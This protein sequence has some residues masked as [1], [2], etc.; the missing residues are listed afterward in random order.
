MNQKFRT[1]LGFF[2]MVVG[3]FEI[4]FGFKFSSVWWLSFPN[5]IDGVMT[6][7]A[8]ILLLI[9]GSV[10]FFRPRPRRNAYHS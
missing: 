3:A 1:P 7:L 2:V 5:S 9:I 8:G 4:G 6:V 10:Y